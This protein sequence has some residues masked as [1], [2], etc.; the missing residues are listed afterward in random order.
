MYTNIG[1]IV[2]LMS[3]SLAFCVPFLYPFVS[4]YLLG[5]FLAVIGSVHLSPRLLVN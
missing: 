3:N 5:T 2:Q 1:R 4:L